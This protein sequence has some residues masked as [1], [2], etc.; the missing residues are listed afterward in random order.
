[1]TMFYASYSSPLG[2]ITVS[3]NGAAVVEVGFCSPT[4]SS[5]SCPIAH[6]AVQ[7]LHEYFSG[8]RQHFELPLAPSGTA[9][10]Q[11][12]WRALLTVPYGQTASY[13]DIA[14][15]LGDVNAVRAVGMANSRN[16]IAIII[17]CHRIIGT[18]G[19]LTGYAGG[20]DKKQWLLQHENV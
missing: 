11:R 18:D 17:P 3:S 12:V 6:H 14:S 10:Q 20:L 7:Q 1:M 9:F 15:Q 5:D 19:S 8:K 2:A 4:S 16:P 13:K